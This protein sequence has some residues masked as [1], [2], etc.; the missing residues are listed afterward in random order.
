MVVGCL[1]RRYI[2]SSLSACVLFT[3]AVGTFQKGAG[4]DWKN[5]KLV[6]RHKSNV[7]VL[8]LL[9]PTVCLHCSEVGT[10]LIA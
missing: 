3:W 10:K 4:N 5:K 9:I 6:W 2:Q 7:N 8:I 1:C